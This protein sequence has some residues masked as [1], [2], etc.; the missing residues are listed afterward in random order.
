MALVVAGRRHDDFTGHVADVVQRRLEPDGRRLGGGCQLRL[1]AGS[2]P[3]AAKMFRDVE[4][5]G[6]NRLARL[7]EC[8]H[9]REFPLQVRLL[10]LGQS[11]AELVEPAVDG[12]AGDLLFD[13]PALVQQRD[14][15]AVRHRLVDGVGVNQAAKGCHRVALL[16]QQRRAGKADIA[17]AWQHAANL[18]C[19][20]AVAAVASGLASVALVHQDEH[21]GVVVHRLAAPHHGVE[22]VDDRC[23]QRR[24]VA[25]QLGQPGPA[26]GAH[27]RHLARLE[28]VPDL[29]VEV[30]SVG[31]DDE[32]RVGNVRVE[33]QRPAEHDHSQ[34]LA[35]SLRVPDHAAPAAALHVELLGAFHRRPHAEELLV[36]GHLAL[37]AVEHREAPHQVEQPSRPAQGEQHP[38][39]RRHRPLALAL[40]GLEIGPRRCQ[41]TREYR[42]FFRPGQLSIGEW[43]NGLIVV[44]RIAPRLPEAPW[45][46][47]GCVAC[48]LTVHAQQQL[49][50][51]KEL[52]DVVRALVADQLAAGLVQAFGRALVLDNDEGNAVD[53]RHDV[54]TIGSGADCAR[55]GELRGHVEDVVAGLL[56]IDEAE[57]VALAVAVDVLGDRGAEQEGVVNVLVRA[58]QAL[59]PVSIRFQPPD[60]L[61][62]VFGIERVGAASVGETVDPQQ[63][64][65]QHAVE[66][67]VAQ[68]PAAPGQRFLLGQR[69]KAQRHEELQR[70]DLGLV[71]FGGVKAQTVLRLS[72]L[73]DNRRVRVPTNTLPMQ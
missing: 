15:C 73:T 45:G 19:E 72:I 44:L 22:L 69:C 27:G 8:I 36:A 4:G 24:L 61:M 9:A 60:G 71:F 26:G 3:V 31:D 57:R 52:R 48:L 1:E 67:D 12:V 16:V 7:G 42:L 51:V 58:A 2:L 13:H 46:S 6:V 62:G 34:R 20:L 17:G 54:A 59:E 37:A 53:E 10:M 25:D 65:G 56:P 41:I 64:F 50:K 29:L 38:V 11:G 30:V 35:R 70:R 68:S 28:G 18:P 47:H 40:Q 23:N 43:R 39:L 55:H 63:L 14:D 21:V 66:R 33:C 32:A 49:G 5:F